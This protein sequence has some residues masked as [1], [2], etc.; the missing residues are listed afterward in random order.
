MANKGRQAAQDLFNNIINTIKELPGRMLDI[1]KN[2]VEGIWNG[3]KNAWGWMKQKVGEFAK[4]IFDG[5]KN[6]LGIHS[7]STLFRDGIGKFI[8][9]GVAV[10]IEADT[11]SALR[12]ID[13][14]NDDI[15][16]EM[17]R[18]VAVEEGSINAKASVKSNNS[19]LNII[20]ATFNI[21]GSVDIDGQ[22]A[23]RLVA[24]AV[25]KTLRAGGV[26]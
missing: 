8:P 23:G 17:N 25:S 2:I 15:I 18:A 24:P 1:G 19:M 12:A 10:G 20:K 4:G 9:Q 21:D 11:D 22:K 14:M 26:Y 13:K 7:P 16:S 5:M 3:I 6:A